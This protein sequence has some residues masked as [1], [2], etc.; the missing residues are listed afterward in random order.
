MLGARADAFIVRTPPALASCSS[1]HRSNA[2]FSVAA[3]RDRV[4]PSSAAVA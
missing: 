2:A 1:L 4:A 3:G